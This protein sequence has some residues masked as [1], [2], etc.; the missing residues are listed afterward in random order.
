LGL[1]FP[2][3]RDDDLERRLL[4]AYRA[5]GAADPARYVDVLG[6]LPGDSPE[7]ERLVSHVTV[8]E[9]Y[10]FRDRSFLEALEQHV[11]RGLIE[12]RRREGMRRLRIWSAGCSSG[13]EAYSLAML[14]DGLL[15]DRSDWSV[16][17]LA[18]DVN[19]SVLSAARRG[20]Y[21][22][23]SFRETPEP[24]RRQYFLAHGDGTF[25]LTPSI[26]EM[27]TFAPLNLAEEV[28]PSSATNTSAMD[29]IL[30][31]NV[32]MYFTREVQRATVGRLQSA[33]VE[34][35]WLGVSPA[36]A[37]AELM[38]PLE[39][40]NFPGAILFRKVAE[41]ARSPAAAERP[42]QA[43][44]PPTP[45]RSPLPP[46]VPATLRVTEQPGEGADLLE[47]ARAAADCGNLE[48]ARELCREAVDGNPLD[49]ESHLLLAAIEQ[50][51]DDLGAAAAAIRSAIYLA[52]DSASTHFALGSLL[53]RQG[54]GEKARRSMATVVSLL[55]SVPSDQAVPGAD[56][57]AAGRLLEIAS[58][59]LEAT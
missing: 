47:L 6:T 44:T 49:L 9:T 1:D 27:V 40:V 52:P 7:W 53:L 30:C 15:P 16:T 23:W 59:H 25:E 19:P 37:S 5:S 39:P 51:R 42:R 26:R 48:R 14:V 3:R 41:R 35:G 29:L 28:Y 13:E 20:I 17:I 21:R 33:L 18:T 22:E 31:R 54:R 36:E 45:L 57:L 58:A 12:R 10:F 56:G 2:E 24:V 38:R 11:L 43:P 50:E 32:I 34:G 4:R 8:G 55:R 46:R